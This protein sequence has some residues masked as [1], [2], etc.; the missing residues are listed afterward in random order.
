MPRLTAM[1]AAAVGV[2]LAA[3]AAPAGAQPNVVVLMTDDQTQASMRYM[4]R[5]R[6]LLG[7]EG[8]TF[9]QTIATFPLCCPSRVTQLT[10]QYSHNHGVL[11]NSGPFGGYAAF[12]HTNV[13]PAWLQEAGYRTMHVGR[14]LN[15]YEADSGVPSG[16]SD[17]HA[18]IGRDAFDYSSWRI[19]ENGTIRS[20]PGERRPQE[21]QTDFLARRAVELIERAAR[22]ERPFFLSLWFVAPHRGSPLDSDDLPGVRSPSPAPRHRDAFAASA[23]PRPPSFDEADVY[24]KPQVVA[25][26]PRLG[27][28]IAAAIEESWRQELESLLAVDEAVAEVLGAL[29]RTGV[30]DDTLVLYTSDNGYMHGEHRRATG[31]V[32]PYEESIRVPLLMRG[33]GVPSGRR[34]PRLAA[35]I[36]LAPTIL[37][38]AGVLPH[39]P[40][41]GR[42]L[43][44]LLADPGLEW[45]RDVLIENGR[46]ANTVPPYRGIRTPRFLYVEHR[47]TGEYE[48]Y[49]L[50]RDPHQL[51]SLD[52]Q[53][54]VE[55][56]QRDLAHRLRRLVRC[57]GAG[58]S[59]RPRLRVLV[60]PAAARGRRC[61]REVRV[62]VGGPE[63]ASVV[64]ADVH[65]GRRRVAS[66]REPPFLR[67]LRLR[68][69]VR[70]R[71]RLLRVRVTMHDGRLVT[72]DR[73]L[74]PCG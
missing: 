37:D 58:C 39:R 29:K 45:G 3:W 43:L 32:L 67:S 44:E 72:F 69:A 70:R 40:Q 14:Y 1:L 34:D 66:V 6:K 51:A 20:Y 23:L 2:A 11:H 25:D 31:K 9:P 52:G 26:R 15:G 7:D 55:L 59:T 10:G 13:L 4:T 47:T 36:D 65:V 8:T 61:A 54:H 63:R 19:N 18:A 62:R 16:W 41:D 53:E 38:A 68:R 24:D 42:S 64:R 33:P 27:P 73:R 28:E 49:D 48:L 74:R 35:N 5:T 12:E 57:V 17:W 60:R 71:E 50:G 21:Y 46:G 56:V 22:G 30:L